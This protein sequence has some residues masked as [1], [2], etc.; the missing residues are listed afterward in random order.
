VI[1]EL[2]ERVSNAKVTILKGETE[3]VAIQT[4]VDGEF[5]FDRLDAGNYDIRVHANHYKAAQS[6]IVIVKPKTKCKRA[7]PI[8][9]A[10]GMGYFG[11]SLGKA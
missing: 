5:S 2:G 3:F 6:P 7:L 9:P 8:R 4:D 10:V 11:I 1:N